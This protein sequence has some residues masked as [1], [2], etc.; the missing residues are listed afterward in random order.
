MVFCGAHLVVYASRRECSI[1]VVFDMHLLGLL[2]FIFRVFMVCVVHLSGGVKRR[3][4][5][6][7][8]R[9]EIRNRESRLRLTEPAALF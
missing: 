7:E 4:K 9:H 1:V 3:K 5:E 8:E 2:F 6:K